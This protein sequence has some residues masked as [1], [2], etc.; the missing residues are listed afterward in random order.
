[1]ARRQHNKRFVISSDSPRPPQ[2]RMLPGSAALEA[3]GESEGVGH[4]LCL[5]HRMHAINDTGVLLQEDWM[6]PP[7]G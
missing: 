2:A 6:C 5:K 4:R 1:M 3:S 7:A